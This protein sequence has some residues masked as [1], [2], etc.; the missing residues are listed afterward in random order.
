MLQKNFKKMNKNNV[1]LNS[2][3]NACKSR[4]TKLLVAFSVK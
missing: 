3:K 2:V 4:K 1:N